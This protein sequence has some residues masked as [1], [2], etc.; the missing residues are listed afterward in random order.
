MRLTGGSASRR[1]AYLLC[2]ALTLAGCG[3]ANRPSGGGAVDQNADLR[4]GIKV[5]QSLDPRQAPEAAQMLVGTWPVYDRLIQITPQ[6]RYAPML[7]TKWSFS[8]GGKVLTLTLR[9]GVTFSDG[10]PFNADAVK[11]TLDAY[12][13]AGKTTVQQTLADIARVEVAGPDTVK[14]DLQ[15]PSTTAL[16]ALASPVGG[17]MISPKALHGKDLATHP[18]GTGAYVI[19]SFQPGQK[20]VYKRR[21]DKGGIW[22]PSTGKPATVEINTYP[23]PDAMSNAVKSGQAD[24][25]T[26]AGDRKPIRPLLDSGR[27]QAQPMGTVLNMVGLNLN[28]KAKPYDNVKVR[29]AINYAIDRDAIVQAFVPSSAK[30]VQPWPA[31]MPGFD[32][33]RE[34]A[35]RYDPAQAK[36]LLAEAGYPNGVDGGEILVAQTGTIPQAAEA[37]QANLAAV[38]IK[39]KLRT[40]DVLTLVT[41]WA[42]GKSTGEVMYMSLPSIDAYSWL[43]RLFLDPAWTPAGPDPQMVQLIQGTDVPTLTDAQRAAKVGAAIKYATDNALYAP[44]W[45]GAGGYLGGAKVKGLDDLASVNGGVA[46]FRNVWLVR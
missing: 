39:I 43:R 42:Q 29:Q 27:L 10:T 22:D 2:A 11:A 33:A 30:R 17:G 7:A 28:K 3:N 14:L 16:A 5:P 40:V 32:N 26:W 4:I 15:A 20:V 31:G 13:A 24:I 37:V 45:Q 23:S 46:D 9:K 1:V 44:L 35:Y 38:G 18:V 34:G 41:Q 6:A 25:V 36:R 12:L 8:A 21:T 19:D